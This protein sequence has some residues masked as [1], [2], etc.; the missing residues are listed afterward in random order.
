MLS[1]LV[2]AYPSVDGDW[3]AC[4]GYLGWWLVEF[5]CLEG[6]EV[7]LPS[8]VPLQVVGLVSASGSGWLGSSFASEGAG[9][10]G[11]H[12]SSSRSEF[13]SLGS[14]LDKTDVCFKAGFLV[15]YKDKSIPMVS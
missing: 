12:C 10:N 3:G 4:S 7:L 13:P 2:C 6:V 8:I 1:A 14:G 11:S 5:R 9:G 15:G